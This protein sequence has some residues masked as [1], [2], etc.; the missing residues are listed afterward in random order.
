MSKY[1]PLDV[2]HPANRDLLS[3]NYLL[4]PPAASAA[5][6]S[7]SA[8]ASASDRSPA[9][10]AQRAARQPAAPWGRRERTSAPPAA[11]QTT[12]R[13]SGT[14]WWNALLV[15]VFVVIFASQNGMLVGVLDALRLLARQNGI[16]LPF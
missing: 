4:D 6:A 9:A 3:R 11:T 16:T 5:P 15:S 1:H 7:A 13:R 10:A 8:R 12:G 2:R 14:F